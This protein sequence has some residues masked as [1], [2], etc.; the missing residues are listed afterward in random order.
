MLFFSLEMSHLELTQR[1]LCSEARVDATR[2]RNGKLLEADWPKISHAIGRL[3]EAPIYI[4][5]NPNLTVMEI[6]AKARRL[7]SRDGTSAS[8]SSTTS[9]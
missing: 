6:R 3:G 4:D 2:M 8:S 7:K 5:D 9:S 1:L